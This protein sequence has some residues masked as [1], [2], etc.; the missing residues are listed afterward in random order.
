MH[1]LPTLVLKEPLKVAT[2]VC[3]VT[4]IAAVVGPKMT[5]EKEVKPQVWETVSII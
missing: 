2:G 1:M 5:A 4:Q 3:P